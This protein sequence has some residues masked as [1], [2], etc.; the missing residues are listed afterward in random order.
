MD[1]QYSTA[2]G[3]FMPATDD[4]D[5]DLLHEARRRST[6]IE[7][8]WTTARAVIKAR[9]AAATKYGPHQ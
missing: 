6:R 4:Q 9:D 2:A 5:T 8:L 7:T 3:L 1:E